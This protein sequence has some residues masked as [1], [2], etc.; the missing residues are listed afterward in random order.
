LFILLNCTFFYF[1]IILF[2]HLFIYIYSV[3]EIKDKKWRHIRDAYMKHVS[4]EKNVKS[5]SGGSKRKAYTYAESLSFLNI[6]VK[7]RK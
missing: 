2:I 5:G 1:Y 7:K 4:D 6:T 3:K